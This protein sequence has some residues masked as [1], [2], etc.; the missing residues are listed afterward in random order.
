MIENFIL[1][2]ATGAILTRYNLKLNKFFKSIPR[3]SIISGGDNALVIT[4]QMPDML[5]TMRFGYTSSFSE[6]RM[7]LLNLCTDFISLDDDEHEYG[8]L[9]NMLGKAWFAELITYYRCII[10]I[11]AFLATS[12]DNTNYFIHMQNREYPFAIAG[13]YSNWLNKETGK[14]ETGFA[15]L[16]TSASS[17]LRYVG[18]DRMPFILAEPNVSVWLDL[19][20]DIEK[21]YSLI[22]PVSDELINGYPASGR[23]IN[24]SISITKLQLNGSNLQPEKFHSNLIVA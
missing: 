7:D 19:H 18:I 13:I 20:Q 10:L 8:G 16:T 1:T 23:I 14:N 4:S 17:M 9:H 21:I 12:N 11:D 15:V 5:Q 2:S 6:G 3:P 24:D 22:C